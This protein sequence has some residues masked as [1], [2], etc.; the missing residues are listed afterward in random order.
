M[1]A[2]FPNLFTLTG[3]GS[4]SILTNVVMSIEQHVE[5]VGDCLAH[6]AREQAALIEADEQAEED[7][8]AHVSA[9]ANGTLHVQANSWYMGANIPGKPR[10]MLPY[11]GGLGVYTEICNKVVA[12]GYRGFILTKCS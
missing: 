3:P 1:V 4:P 2:G 12:D 10:V 5:W 9:V 6:M 7:W 11:V 8:V